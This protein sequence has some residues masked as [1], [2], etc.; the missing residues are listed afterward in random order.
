M[1]KLII[2]FLFLSGSSF[3]YGTWDTTVPQGTEAKSLG[4]DRIRELKTDIQT[5][6]QFEGDF[7][8]ISSSTPRFIYT[9]STGTSSARPTGDNAPTG[10]LFINKTTHAIEQFDGTTWQIIQTVSTSS[11][12]SAEISTT[13][14]GNGLAGGGG[15]SLSVNVS[16][17]FSIVGDSITLANDAIEAKH[18]LDGVVSGAELANDLIITGTV[19]IP[20]Q[21]FFS[22]NKTGTDSNVTGDGTSLNITFDTEVYDI[23]NHFSSTAFTAVK[24]GHYLFEAAVAFTDDAGSNR[25]ECAIETSNRLYA[26]TSVGTHGCHISALADMEVG[27]IARV[28]V[29]VTDGAKVVDIV[30]STPVSSY[31]GTWFQGTLIN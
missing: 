20:N 26:T 31:S 10:R 16:T 1:K 23:G 8:G 2:T 17:S 21:V 13:I 9:P 3:S 29:K 22:V 28:L 11:I 12:T 18:I 14:A 25:V 7:P 4:D 24:N 30:P 15:A 27:D 6:L 5:S 19:T